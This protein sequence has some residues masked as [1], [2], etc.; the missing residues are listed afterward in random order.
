MAAIRRAEHKEKSRQKV[1][2]K[3]QKV[4]EVAAR[5]EQRVINQQLKVNTQLVKSNTSN[6]LKQSKP[7]QLEAVD[8]DI[9]ESSNQQG[10]RQTYSGRNI[11]PP[12]HLEAYII[13]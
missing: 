9:A 10:Q 13:E 1:I 5:K 11:Q 4:A 2:K 3:A 7:A 8:R 12:R 6:R